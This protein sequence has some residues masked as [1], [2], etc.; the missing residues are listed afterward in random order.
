MKRV[1]L[2]LLI[3]CAVISTTTLAVSNNEKVEK[4][5]SILNKL[6]QII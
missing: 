4:V 6:T 2:I 1:K 5:C 3:C